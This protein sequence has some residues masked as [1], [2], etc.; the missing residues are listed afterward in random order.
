[1]VSQLGRSACPW[2]ARCCE[3]VSLR[4]R[5]PML[6]FEFVAVLFQFAERDPALPPSFQLPLPSSSLCAVPPVHPGTEHFPD[7]R[8]MDGR[9]FVLTGRDNLPPRVG[10]E[11]QMCSQRREPR[12]RCINF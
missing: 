3:R 8:Q 1:M 12:V 9:H 6:L 10:K 2:A 5:N 4:P 7:L 11:T